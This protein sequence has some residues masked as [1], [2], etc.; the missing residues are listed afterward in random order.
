MGLL[1]QFGGILQQY[2]GGSGAATE[3]ATTHLDQVARELPQNQLSGA[4]SNVFQSPQTG[5]FGQNISDLYRQSNPQQQA[6]ILNQLLPALGAGGLGSLGSL[7]GG[8]GNQF[9]HG[10]NVTPEVAQQLSPD[11][12]AQIANHAQQQNPSIVDQAAGFYAQHPTLV[13]ALGATAAAFALKNIAES[14]RR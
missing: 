11:Q 5:T 2:T 10:T 1:D 12:V 4:L 14:Q 3:Q 13:K 6:G 8:M 9:G 7:L